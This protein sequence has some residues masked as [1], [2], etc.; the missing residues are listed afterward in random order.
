[1]SSR[2]LPL[3]LSTALTLM[4]AACTAGTSTVPGS[5]GSS[6][7]DS[8]TASTDPTE[9]TGTALGPACKEYIACCA[10]L[11]AKT[12]QVAVS[13]ESIKTQIE[14]AEANG[15]S[16]ASFEAGCKSGVDSF[17]SAGY[18]KAAEKPPPPEPKCV[19][20]C[21]SDVECAN[22]CPALAGGVQCCD[23]TTRICFGSK[24]SSC[25]K[26]DDPGDPPPPSY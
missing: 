25:P 18:C 10:E 13:C 9:P 11:A 22:S 4:V 23:L 17:K 14:T 7:P 3:L 15:V 26:P 20:S 6:K 12:P 2:P 24:T 5:N 8:G 16:T 1:M 21:A 19:S